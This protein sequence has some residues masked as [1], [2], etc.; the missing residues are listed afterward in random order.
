MHGAP[1]A[2]KKMNENS[3]RRPL[4]CSGSSE[5]PTDDGRK[6]AERHIDNGGS[7]L[8]H[9]TTREVG[10]EEEGGGCLARA[11]QNIDLEKEQEQRQEGAGSRCFVRDG[12]GSGGGAGAG[13]AGDDRL[14]GFG[15]GDGVVGD[16][17]GGGA[18]RHGFRSTGQDRDGNASTSRGCGVVDD[19]F[20]GEE[21]EE[22]ATS[23]ESCYADE[24]NGDDF[25][26][27]Y[28]L[29][30]PNEFADPALEKEDLT[31]GEHVDP[32]LFVAEPCCGVEGLE[33]QDRATGR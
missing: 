17:G 25:S 13:G 14:P 6:M 20:E 23:D 12:G 27:S 11:K 9:K 3:R 19:Y 31:V 21:K 2:N 7:V 29:H 5:T 4:Q 1:S 22:T 28:A 16:C 10:M 26:V 8:R 24:D 33:I 30:Y 15:A 32:S 18:G